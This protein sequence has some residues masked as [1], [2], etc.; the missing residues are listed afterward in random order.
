MKASSSSWIVPAVVALGV[1]LCW[2]RWGAWTSPDVESYLKL[3]E[4][5]RFHQVLGFSTSNG[6]V[7]PSTLR[8]PLYPGLIAAFWWGESAP[9]TEMLLLQVVLG[10]LTV[11]L[12]YQIACDS[13]GKRVALLASFSMAVAPMTCQ[14]TAI[15]LTET[16]FTFLFVLGIFLWGR[17]R[18]VLCGI[19]FGLATLTRPTLL[20]F[21]IILPAAALFKT[22]RAQWRSLLIISIIALTVSSVWVIR[23]AITFRR[24]IPTG[25]LAGLTLLC[26]TIDM[27][28]IG[29]KVWT[30][31]GWEL[32]DMN[33]HPLLQLDNTLNEAQRE[34]VIK[35][36]AIERITRHPLDWLI[37]R[38]KQYP[39][40][41]I[42]TGDYMLGRYNV[43]IRDALFAPR[44][45]VLIVK[46]LFLLGNLLV[47]TLA[48]SGVYRERARFGSLGHLLLPLAF[49][50]M[51][52]LPLWIEARYSLPIMPLVAIFASSELILILTSKT[53]REVV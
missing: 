9:I 28:I 24:F 3:A 53:L 45:F 48:A 17:K 50:L 44:P 2:I 30:G 22:W 14:H 6:N 47:I 36:R 51:V 29:F 46:S 49:M 34:E 43:S 13:F 38:S 5:L 27:E 33:T 39:K 4:N 16:L 11:A 40:L 20:P 37:V 23:N 18:F 52:H 8:P 26:G 15:L 31:Q 42:D 21:L 10:S 1:R 32:L 35:Q 7:I 41:F 19:A 12:V 25:S